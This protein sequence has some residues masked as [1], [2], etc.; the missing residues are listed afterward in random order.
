[1]AKLA[2]T[3][4]PTFQD[5]APWDPST[6][7]WPSSCSTPNHQSSWAEVVIRGRKTAVEGTAS[8]PRLSLS[9]HFAF[10]SGD[11]PTLT[12][13]DL[14]PS[15]STASSPPA[16]GGVQQVALRSAEGPHQQLS[17]QAMTSASQRN[18]L[19]EAVLRRSQSPQYPKPGDNPPH[20]TASLQHSSART[21]LPVT[22]GHSPDTDCPPPSPATLIVGDSI[23]RNIRFFNA[24]TR[25]FPG[26]TIPVI[27]DKLPGLWRSL[28]SSIYQVVFHVGTNDLARQ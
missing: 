3:T 10:L 13:Y 23:V 11:N 22:P 1:M 5:T 18:I 20:G 19:K 27:L 24:A 8:P 25:C 28:L 14:D 2:G 17:S 7:P 15:P 21:L 12:H 6:C 9:N 4:M 16:A 26:A